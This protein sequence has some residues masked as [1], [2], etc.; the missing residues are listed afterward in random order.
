M[1]SS[2]CANGAVSTAA[3]ARVVVKNVFIDFL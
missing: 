2:A 3:R 1:P